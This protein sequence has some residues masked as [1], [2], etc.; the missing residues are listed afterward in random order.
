MAKKSNGIC[1]SAEE[2]KANRD[3]LIAAIKKGGKK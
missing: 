3:A 1:L 2:A